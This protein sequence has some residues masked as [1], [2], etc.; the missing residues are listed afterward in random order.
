MDGILATEYVVFAVL[1]LSL[2]VDANLAVFTVVNAL[3]L[4]PAPFPDPDRLVML[5]RETANS[6]SNESATFTRANLAGELIAAGSTI[7]ASSQRLRQDGANPEI[8]VLRYASAGM[9]RMPS[10]EM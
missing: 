5:M 8:R 9:T 4:R 7:L 1:S 10:A 6:A 2:A 3:W